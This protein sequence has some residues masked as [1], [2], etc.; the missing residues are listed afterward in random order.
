MMLRHRRCRMDKVMR[1][2][3]QAINF[4][5]FMGVVG[6]F[7]I[8]PEFKYLQD[9]EAMI[10]LAIKHASQRQKECRK[11]SPEELAKLPPNMRVGMDC[12]RERSPLDID[13]ALDGKSVI[14]KNIESPG[15]HKDQTIDIFESIK[16]KAGKHMLSIKMNDS[17]RVKGPTFTH[18]QDIALEPAQ[19]LV[20]QFDT[21]AGK[22]IID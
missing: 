11:M 15:L 7:S 22:F 20:I 14:A 1:I 4:T 18:E 21:A 9:D 19:L 17:V 10:T 16:V 3:L 2:F 5:V 13:V 12:P 8:Y 6:Y